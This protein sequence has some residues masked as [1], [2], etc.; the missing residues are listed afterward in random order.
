[1]LSPATCVTDDCSIKILSILNI[2]SSVF[3]KIYVYLPHEGRLF[4][5]TDWGRVTHTC[6]SKLTIIGPDNG[7]LP[8]RGQA[9]IWT[10]A[11]ILL[12]WT[13]W[14]NLNLKQNSYIFIQ[15][16]AFENVVCIMTAIL[17][18]PQCVKCVFYEDKAWPMF[19]IC[20]CSVVYIIMPYGTVS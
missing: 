10:S 18:W 20:S 6:I 17:S 9:I 14:T 16:N 19:H 4:L 15:E 5:L 3:S 8:G 7:L 11:G 12:I 13:L 1:M 2:S